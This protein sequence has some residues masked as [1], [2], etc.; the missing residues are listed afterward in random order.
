MRETLPW[1]D[2][3]DWEA[4]GGEETNRIYKDVIKKRSKD[5]SVDSYCN[6]LH[7]MQSLVSV[8]VSALTNPELS[9]LECHQLRVAEVLSD[10]VG[11][12]LKRIEKGLKKL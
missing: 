7:Q 3:T 11:Q 1:D 12:N 9:K 4:T 10:Y 6:E 8:C 2:Y 5:K